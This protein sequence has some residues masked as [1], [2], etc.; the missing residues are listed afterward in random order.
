[1]FPGELRWFRRVHK[2]SEMIAFRQGSSS[3]WA[4]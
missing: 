1:V 2:D 3:I 4:G